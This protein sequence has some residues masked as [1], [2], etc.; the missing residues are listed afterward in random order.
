MPS[1]INPQQQQMHNIHVEQSKRSV[2]ERIQNLVPAPMA[3]ATL[4][5]LDTMSVLQMCQLGR[6]IVQDISVRVMNVL[7]FFRT[8]VSRRNNPALINP[9]LDIEAILTY[10]KFL[11]RKL[12]E[13]R[14]RVDK[15]RAQYKDQPLGEDA[16]FDEITNPEPLQE[17]ATFSAAKQAL[18][19]QFE[20]NRAKIIDLNNRTKKLEWFAATNDPR[21]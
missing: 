20:S 7:T 1:Q 3:F 12:Q 16:F 4:N 11:F 13:I 2:Q 5:K 10:T 18:M 9:A 6:E 17:D 14:I 21:I 8:D 19:E 15:A